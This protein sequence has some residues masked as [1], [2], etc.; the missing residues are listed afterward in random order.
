MLDSPR[1]KPLLV[2]GILLLIWGLVACEHPA[3][4][5]SAITAYFTN[6]ASPS[7]NQALQNALIDSLNHATRSI[8]VAMYNF[9]LLEVGNALRNARKNGVTV[10]M[11]VDSDAMDNSLLQQ[12]RKEGF[13][14]LGDRREALMHNKFIVIDQKTVWTGSLNLTYS[15]LTNDENNLVRIESP[16]LAELYTEEFNEM[17]EEDIF[18]GG[19]PLETRSVLTIHGSSVWVYFS[20][21]D[22][23]SQA[24][25]D[26]VL[27]AQT[28]IDILAYNLT[29]ND[30]RDALLEAAHRGLDVRIVF[31][32]DQANSTGSD[33]QSLKNA[34]LDVHLDGSSGLMHHKVIILDKSTVIFGSYNFTR[35]A[36]LNNDE[37]MLILQNKELAKQFTQTFERIYSQAQ[38]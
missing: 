31:D 25:L 4:S 21:E 10:R 16:E 38:P 20:P 15:G 27:R 30:L 35:N 33:Y 2:A 11:V 7:Q 8:D 18:G 9:N 6:P 26:Q 19:K 24:I 12:L 32:A 17:F 34:G 28:S 23:P 36:D 22:S 13:E 29:L 5:Q 3:P 1:L 37:N 14:V